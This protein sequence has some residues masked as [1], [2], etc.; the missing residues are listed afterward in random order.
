MNKQIMLL[1]QNAIN[2]SGLKEDPPGSN[3]GPDIIKYANGIS[4]YAPGKGLAWCVAFVHYC[5]K[6]INI[7][8]LPDTLLVNEFYEYYKN[9]YPDTIIHS[10]T[11]L[12]GDIVL[13]LNMIDYHNHMGIVT[14]I[15]GDGTAWYVSGNTTNPTYNTPEINGEPNDFFVCNKPLKKF[16]SLIRL[17]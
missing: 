4:G 5:L 16:N 12:P 2:E 11:P 1:I 9:K 15:D 7:Q 3:E 10:L 13:R 17:F 6:S 8:D 14:S